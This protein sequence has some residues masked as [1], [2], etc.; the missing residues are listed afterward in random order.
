ME[1][2]S[3]SL[4]VWPYVIDQERHEWSI[5]EELLI[6]IWNRL[7]SED[8]IKWVFHDGS[9][10]D[11]FSFLVFLQTPGVFPLVVMD[12][13]KRQP[14]HIAWLTDVGRQHAFV[15]HC[16]VGK[17]RR[18]TWETMTAYWKGLGAIKILLG[19]TPADNKR[20]VKFVEKICRANIVGAIPG[21][22]Y[23]AQANKFVSG[24]MSYYELEAENGN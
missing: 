4:L 2:K 6:E 22:C 3:N 17:Y 20:A 1:S 18:G 8:K 15:H 14:V 9:I 23:V 5:P 21:I 7:V 24:V 19:L 10:Q 11:G 16:S 13:E 12:A